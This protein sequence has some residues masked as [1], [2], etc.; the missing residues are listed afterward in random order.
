P[1]RTSINVSPSSVAR[2]GSD[3]VEQTWRALP[4]AATRWSCHVPIRRPE[5]TFVEGQGTLDAKLAG[6]PGGRWNV[7]GREGSSHRRLSDSNGDVG[8]HNARHQAGEIGDAEL[9]L[10]PDVVGSA[11]FAL[12]KDGP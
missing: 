6:S 5:D 3:G 4:S 10:G 7:A 11:R 1:S 9:R 12:E 2:G 8:S